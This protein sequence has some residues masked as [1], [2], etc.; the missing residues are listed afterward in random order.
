MKNEKN[1]NSIIINFK[2]GFHNTCCATYVSWV[3]Q[4]VGLVSREDHS[5]SANTLAINLKDKGW[6]KV[7]KP[8]PGGVMVF[9]H[10]VQI[11]GDDG[12]I[13]NAGSASSI[14]KAPSES[15][16]KMNYSY[17]LRAPKK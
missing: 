11:Y 5:N 15:S 8:Q 2:N 16:G 1:I 10:H 12:K 6:T 4:E 3:L 14:R 13:Y 9:D 17:C 7:D